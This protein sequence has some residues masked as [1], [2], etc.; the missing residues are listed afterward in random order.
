MTSVTAPRAP[1]RVLMVNKYHYPRGGAEHYMF[2]LAAMLEQHGSQVDYFS[3]RHPKN[4]PCPTDS[5]FVS[6]VDF[7]HPPGGLGRIGVAGR[8]VYSR[9]AR[10][11]MGRLLDHR[12]V[13]LAHVHNIYHQLSPSLLAPLHRRRIPVVM[14]VHDFKLVCPVY[15]LL[16]HG[17]IC[18]RCVGHGFSQAV[19]RRCNRG[20]LSGSA[21]VAGETWLHRRL[22]LY[23]DGI[24]VF[25]TPSSFAR[26]RLVRG[27]YPSERVLVIPNCV[28]AGDYRPGYQPGDYALYLG[29]LS[30]EKGVDMLVRAA[31]VSGAS[32]KLVGEG[33]LREELERLVAETGADV[34][35]LGYRSG[36]ELAE[37]VRGASSVVM[38]SV[39][40]DNCPL[41]VIEAMAWGKPVVASRVG[42]IPELVRDGDEGLLVPPGD[43]D[44]LGRALTDLLSS[45]E[46]AEQMGRRG[47]ARVEARY[48]AEGHF[49]AV[50][51]AYRLA[52]EIARSAR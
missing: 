44:A 52:G 23:R 48:D 38:P 5:Y 36:D 19:R 14:T 9:E 32:V 20:S 12:Q 10:L 1:T 49:R 28:V 37:I 21:L 27:G 45:P 22:S 40:H 24:D 2:R 6:E 50:R 31:A 51:E 46:L 15:S 34:E 7:E 8:A 41:A 17:E 25:V 42:G 13:D 3:M 30:R 26:E 35:L 16:S 39:C 47:R 29:R 33:P 11:K 4:E 43:V 18:E